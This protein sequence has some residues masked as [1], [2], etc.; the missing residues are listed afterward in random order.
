MT[1]WFAFALGALCGALG[2]YLLALYVG[3]ETAA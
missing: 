3:V 1:R 2:A